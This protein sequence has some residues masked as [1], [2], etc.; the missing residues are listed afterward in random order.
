MTGCDSVKYAHSRIFFS[1][2]L[3]Q[4]VLLT[5]LRACK[6]PRRAHEEVFTEFSR[7]E[8]ETL[9]EE[10][11]EEEN[12]SC[13]FLLLIQKHVL[14]VCILQEVGTLDLIHY[15]VKVMR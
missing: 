14:P 11:E 13:W 7:R 5:H 9:W 2:S 3:S 6:Q 4:R 12:L 8:E 10:E 1:M 15:K